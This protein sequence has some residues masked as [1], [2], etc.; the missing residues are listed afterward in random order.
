MK[1]GIW[2]FTIFFCLL[3]SWWWC[4]KRCNSCNDPA[5]IKVNSHDQTVPTFQWS[6]SEGR[7]E[8]D[9]AVSS[10]SII[11]DPAA[12]VIKTCIP[13][14]FFGVEVI[15]NDFE[16]GIKSIQ[17]DGGFEQSCRRN[18]QLF[19][20]HGQVEKQSRQSPLTKC[21]LKAL[22]LI[23]DHIEEYSCTPIE[24]VT[25]SITFIAIA[26]NHAGIKDTSSL[27]VRFQPVQ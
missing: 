1:N 25:S 12:G 23:D 22:G 7:M 17:L 16:S 19:L 20:A 15:A 3:G 5:L 26:E 24:L 8:N 14:G 21:G 11:T 4:E 10:I 2:I 9:H 13:N 6:I 27:T 18:G